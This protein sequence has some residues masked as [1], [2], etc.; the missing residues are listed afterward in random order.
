[1]SVPYDEWRDRAWASPPASSFADLD[2]ELADLPWR[3]PSVDD[4]MR[5]LY[6]FREED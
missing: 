2:V 6:T 4:E 5:I 3:G 1:M